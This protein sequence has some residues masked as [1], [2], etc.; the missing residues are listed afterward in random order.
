MNDL[1]DS[2]IK[3]SEVWLQYAFGDLKVA[4][5]E[6][7][8]DTPV[9]HT[10]CF[11]CQGAAEKF[12][13]GFLIFHGWELIKTHDVAELLKY[14]TKYD[15]AFATLIPLGELLNEYITAGRYP[16]DLAI[17]DMG[18]DEAQEALEATREIR[19]AVI[20]RMPTSSS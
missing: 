3:V 11:L 17:E 20:A 4:E 19:N 14:S 10:I 16:G 13:K 12:L 5:R 1:E 8:N 6:I 15:A 18:P 7:T 9:Y 2:P